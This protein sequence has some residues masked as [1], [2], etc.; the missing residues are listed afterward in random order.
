MHFS[1]FNKTCELHNNE[2]VKENITGNMIDND[3]VEIISLGQFFPKM[4][5]KF[6]LFRGKLA[7]MA[8]LNEGS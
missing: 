8:C 6:K 4:V 2:R 1:H 7:L 5:L 3:N